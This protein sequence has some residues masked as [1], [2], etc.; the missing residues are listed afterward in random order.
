VILAHLARVAFALVF[1]AAASAKAL[2]LPRFV[3]QIT[4]FH[5]A[6]EGWAPLL[7]RLFVTVEF[8]IGTASLV[9][10]RPRIS[11]GAG[12]L[13]LVFFIGVLGYAM[14]T[15]YAGDCG[16]FG[17]A[18]TAAGLPAITKN[19]LFIIFGLVALGVLGGRGRHAW[20]GVAALAGLG[21]GLLAPIVGSTLPFARLVTESK[22]GGRFDHI[23]VEE[24]AGDL[25]RGSYLVAI[26]DPGEPASVAAA[27]PLNALAAAHLPPVVG[28]FQGDNTAMVTFLFEHAPEFDGMGHAPREGLRR[29]YRRLPVVLALRDGE[30]LAAWHEAVPAIEE[31]GDVF[32]SR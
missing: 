1:L 20:Q 24:F 17:G 23:V 9:N 10:F 5:V 18:A 7:A 25:A 6:P 31:A 27:A 16:C 22:P 4:G 19:V 14:A 8:G 21:L 15:G 2:D 11:I 32:R 28:V 29:F 26:L 3:E 12:I 13:L 30:I